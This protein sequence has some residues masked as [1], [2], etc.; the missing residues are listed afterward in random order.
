MIKPQWF[1]SDGEHI[2][3]DTD[4]K[5]LQ[6]FVSTRETGFEVALLK[7]F[8]V[9]ILIGQLSYKQKAD[10][11]NYHHGY[12]YQQTSRFVYIF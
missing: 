3:Y 5:S 4:W 8:D 1:I 10:I 7:L 12:D 9:E 2:T 11:Y 6:Y